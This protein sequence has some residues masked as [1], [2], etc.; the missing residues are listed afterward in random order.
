[1]PRVQSVRNKEDHGNHINAFVHF[2]CN[3]L[4][5]HGKRVD[6]CEL[7]T[8]G[9]THFGIFVGIFN[10]PRARLSEVWGSTSPMSPCEEWEQMMA[11]YSEQAEEGDSDTGNQ[12]QA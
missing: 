5:F 1:M 2:Q 6:S 11:T 3:R 8:T 7:G 12:A 10:H 9:C 4:G